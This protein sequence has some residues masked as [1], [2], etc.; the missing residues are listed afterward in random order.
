[1]KA[2]RIYAERLGWRVLPIRPGEKRPAIADWVNEA[3][4]DL[5]Q[6]DR[7][8]EEFPNANIGIAAGHS[9]FVLDVDPRNGGDTTLAA[10]IETHGELPPTVEAGTPSGGT[11][12]LF[13]MVPGLANTAGKLGKGLD[14]RGLGGQI[15][16]APS[17]T[18]AG[19]YRW[20]RAPWDFE[21]LP[22]PEWLLATLRTTLTNSQVGGESSTSRGYFPPASP[23]VLAAAADA[24]TFHGPAVDGDGG[25]LHTV[26]A[27]AILTHDYA[28]T[29]AEAWP[30]F[31][32]WNQTCAPPWDLDGLRTMLGRGAKY[33]KLPYGCKRKLDALEALKKLIADWQATKSHDEPTMLAMIARAR[34]LR[35]TDPAMRAIAERDLC[36]ASGLAAK[37]ISLPPVYRDEK[38]EPGQILVG[39]K[40]YECADA[41][42]KAI[43]PLVFQRNGVLCEVVKQERTFIH[44]LEQA[45]IQDLMSRAATY[46]REDKEGLTTTVAPAPVAGI[47]QAR[48]THEGV[49]ILEAITTAP[50]FLADGSILFERGYNEQARLFLEP[51]VTVQIPDLPG[52]PEAR[53]GVAIFKALLSDF[54]FAA[55]ED[56]SS[57][58]AGLLSPLVKAATGNAPAPLFCVTASSPG[59]GKS[60]LTEVISRVVTG[61]AAENSPYNC[62][63]PGEWGKRLTAFVK[64]AS[65][66]RVLDNVNGQIGDDGLNRLI[67]SST[68]SD[69]LLGASE[70]PPLP[71]V[72]TWFAT[73]NNIEPVDDT[74]RR[75]LLVRIEVDTE[76][77]QERTGFKLPLLAEYADQHRSELL[78]AA[79]TILRAYHLAGRPDQ[80]LP[81]WGSFVAWS[82]LI[83][84]ALVWAGLPDP[85]KTQ[86]RA[87]SE[88]NEPENDAHDFWISVVKD[89]D[90]TPGSIV[91]LANQRDAQGVLGTR[92]PMSAVYLR[93]FIGRFVDKPRAGKRIRRSGAAYRVEA[94]P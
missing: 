75:V 64:A 41:S 48:R 34:E 31:V 93:R 68:W 24:L 27:A 92:E 47:L 44:D 4:S 2:A 18:D 52:L 81:P 20:I 36:G 58:L 71:Q 40:L 56:F 32:E 42:M 21:T 28:L 45:R 6:I 74:V 78:S 53:A 66:V 19:E 55:P 9:F 63:D 51:S 72:T 16:V 77:P 35:F 57:W 90:G 10:L 69:R 5:E 30:L 26:H 11:H 89:S 62:K 13:R 33:G 83:R 73:G 84:G 12:Y 50:V 54:R 43:A 94:I 1:M 65:P 60:L 15:V 86:Q 76:R 59:A 67:T 49:R 22:A 79:L 82:S 46:V 85:F 91:V 17:R 87:S 88:L 61:N 3:S 7:W 80:N 29:D 39:V 23:T 8:I 14:T 70:A 38:P 37:A 25:G